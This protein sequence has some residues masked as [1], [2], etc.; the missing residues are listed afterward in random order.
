MKYGT[1]GFRGNY[2]KIIEISY[3]IGKILCYLT[4]SKNENFGVMITASHNKYLDN[5]L[6][7]VDKNG[8]MLSKEYEILLENYIS[9]IFN[10]PSILP[11]LKSGC[12][13]FIGNDTRFSCGEI[14][15]NIVMGINSFK[16]EVE[17]VDLG[18]VT[19]PQHHF[20]VKY[21][22]DNS[23]KYIEKYSKLNLNL[24]DLMIDCA[25]GVGYLTLQKIIKT[26]INLVNININNHKLLN[27]KSGS[28]YIISNIS[29]KNSLEY[30]LNGKLGCSLDG[31]AD[32]FIFYYNEFDKLN[33]LDGDY[34]SLLYLLAVC[35]N[36]NNDLTND[37]SNDFKIGYVHTPY[38][39]KA[40]INYIKNL[41]LNGNKIN[42]VCAATG[43]KNL[44]HEALRYDISVYFE[45]NGHGTILINNK[46]LL[47]QDFFKKISLLNNEVVG[48]GISGIFCVKYFLKSL[49]I[50]FKEWFNLVKKNK[51][52]L[53][54]K[55]VPNKEIFE[56]NKVGD[57]LLNP[58]LLQNKLD[59]IMKEN[60][61]FCFIR[62]S[63]T[64][65]VIRIYIEGN[66]DLN[67]VKNKISILL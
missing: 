47:E 7:I 26:D 54:K 32:R 1:A 60:K 14:K 66:V 38:T 56:T 67:M 4:C 13:I 3:K 63:G 34:I 43:V 51:F 21:N 33:I 40:I 5:G 19:T 8:N 28:D 59:E 25:N 41:N 24:S 46:K 58:P 10:I 65:N 16:N 12:R 53:Y 44:H 52:I 62:P 2:E 42:V 29:K 9:G 20:L 64:E 35:K 45:S 27:D 15:K 18:F 55:E 31:D 48:D 17:I 6:K 36:L 30:D 37:L 23:N 39:N 22:H 57:R 11:N 50:T 61:C 49:N